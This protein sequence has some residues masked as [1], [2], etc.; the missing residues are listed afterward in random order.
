MLYWVIMTTLS[1][2][3]PVYNEYDQIDLTIKK[4]IQLKK[5]KIWINIYRWLSTDNS[6]QKLNKIRKKIDL[7]KFKN[8]KKGLGSAI[9]IGIKNL[10]LNIYAF[11]CVIYL[12]I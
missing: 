3:I 5:N 9:N 6:Y 10:N 8:K 1:I 2:I 4:Q 7:L 11:L 12:V